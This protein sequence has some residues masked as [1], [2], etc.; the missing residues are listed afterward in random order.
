[1][2][3]TTVNQVLDLAAR[4]DQFLADIKAEPIATLTRVAGGQVVPDT[5]VYRLIVWF[6]GLIALVTTAGILALVAIKDSLAVPDG[7][8][9]LGSAAVGALAGL[10]APSPGQ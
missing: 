4:D 6:L 3:D 8:I 1:M 2:A 9:A 7:V 5:K 10:L